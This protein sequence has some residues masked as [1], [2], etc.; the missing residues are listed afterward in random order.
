MCLRDPYGSRGKARGR[1]QPSPPSAPPGPQAKPWPWEV[2]GSSSLISV[3][4][5]FHL[6][7]PA[8]YSLE[9]TSTQLQV[10]FS[11]AARDNT[12]IFRYLFS[13]NV[14]QYFHPP[15]VLFLAPVLVFFLPPKDVPSQYC[16]FG[17]QNHCTEQADAEGKVSQAT[18]T[19]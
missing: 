8:D 7:S 10:C 11:G 2:S 18:V 13:Q 16:L 15:S 6:Q 5:K 14:Q 19:R 17:R 12:N 1:A 9:H 4:P 3:G